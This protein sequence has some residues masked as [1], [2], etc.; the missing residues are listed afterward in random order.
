MK[1]KKSIAPGSHKHWK[2][3][4]DYKA[5]IR[6]VTEDVPIFFSDVTQTYQLRKQNQSPTLQNSATISRMVPKRWTPTSP[7]LT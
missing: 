6:P 7:G 1:R 5:D 2:V 3:L 4:T